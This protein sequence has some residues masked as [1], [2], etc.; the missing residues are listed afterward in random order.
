[1]V[2]QHPSDLG[3][4][5]AQ[6]YHP[7][8]ND[9]TAMVL[10]RMV[11][12]PQ[13][14]LRLCKS[15]LQLG[16]STCMIDF[17]GKVNDLAQMA[18]IT[19]F[20]TPDESFDLFDRVYEQTHHA[21]FAEMAKKQNG[22]DDEKKTYA[23]FDFTSTRE[24][25][26]KHLSRSAES[27]TLGWT[28]HD[29]DNAD[30]HREIY[31]RL[32]AQNTKF[33]FE[34]YDVLK[35]IARVN[36][37]Y[38]FYHW[39][40]PSTD[41][42]TTQ[43][44]V[45]C[46]TPAARSGASFPW[47]GTF[48]P[49]AVVRLIEPQAQSYAALEAI[50]TAYDLAFREMVDAYA[51]TDEFGARANAVISEMERRNGRNPQP[52]QA[53]ALVE[54]PSTVISAHIW[55]ET[56]L[57]FFKRTYGKD[58]PSILLFVAGSDLNRI[59]GGVGGELL[60]SVMINRLH[61][62][63]RNNE[64]ILF[65]P[66]LGSGGNDV[67]SGPGELL[68][69]GAQIWA[70][71]NTDGSHALLNVGIPRT[72]Q[73]D[74]LASPRKFLEELAAFGDQ[75]VDHEVFR[76]ARQED[77][78]TVYDATKVLT[79]A[80]I[81]SD[82]D[83]AD[84]RK[85]AD[86]E[87]QRMLW[88][89]LTM[90]THINRVTRFAW[91]INNL[92]SLLERHN[93][94]GRVGSSGAIAYGRQWPTVSDYVNGVL[95]KEQHPDPGDIIKPEH[96]LLGFMVGTDANG[97]DDASKNFIN[98]QRGAMHVLLLTLQKRLDKVPAW[99]GITRSTRAIN[100]AFAR[101][102][103]GTP[104]TTVHGIGATLRLLMK[105]PEG[106]VTSDDQSAIKILAGYA[107]LAM[108]NPQLVPIEQVIS[109]IR[110]SLGMPSCTPATDPANPEAPAPAC[111][112]GLVVIPPPA[113]NGKPNPVPRQAIPEEVQQ[114]WLYY[115][116][117]SG[118]TMIR[119]DP[120]NGP[121]DDPIFADFNY[122]K[123]DIELIKRRLEVVFP[124]S[125]LTNEIIAGLRDSEGEPEGLQITDHKGFINYL[126]KE[127]ISD[128]LTL[129]S[130]LTARRGADCKLYQECSGVN[131]TYAEEYRTRLK[132]LIEDARFQT[133]MKVMPD[134]SQEMPVTIETVIFPDGSRI[135]GKTESRPF[136][137]YKPNELSRD[138]WIGLVKEKIVPL[139]AIHGWNRIG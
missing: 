127:Y 113:Q 50:N 112:P 19:A 67:R 8:V 1:V 61:K 17:E 4:L 9:P 75:P 57:G 102:V 103:L 52:V 16:P 34:R 56:Y 120:A 88:A 62:L 36:L 128:V 125:A 139:L 35:E 45:P 82:F 78:K 12:T 85:N 122:A 71:Q 47:V 130:F 51:L 121:S 107:A 118:F 138:E 105:T 27:Y 99:T 55:M 65:I 10:E 28:H 32:P 3:P 64:N 68:N 15:V 59:I 60:R 93:Q 83:P 44:T 104:L 110:R 106:K 117:N 66:W 33:G 23:G 58:A 133:A 46:A 48:P 131:M 81:P 115:V 6:V 95:Y 109:V 72:I 92:K 29:Q 134:G 123:T 136:N 74:A 13:D 129:E 135:E 124:E 21:V 63:Q 31:V 96:G 11:V 18:H 49:T 24:L 54:D 97:L 89:G 39:P 69:A 77:I 126:V 53:V 101:Y 14:Q 42:P 98:I 2:T 76:L 86:K 38:M 84:T 80:E 108:G 7:Q 70:E 43:P 30:N 5:I 73:A 37:R 116:R 94:V 100:D 79:T 119:T 90:F 111:E 41:Q 20:A 26:L 132:A 91:P 40:A 114:L 87:R 137:K 25:W 22:T